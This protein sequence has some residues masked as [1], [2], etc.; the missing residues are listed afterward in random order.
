MKITGK[1]W[2]LYYNDKSAWPENAWH[3]DEF[4]TVNGKEA[5]DDTRLDRVK[6][7]DEIILVGGV[8]F[9]NS[10]DTEGHSFESHFKKWRKTQS[11]SFVT[12]FIPFEKKMDVS[13]ALKSLGIKI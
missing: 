5:D 2:K 12:I 1:E 11:G 7:E 6:D 3:E 13:A 8:R 9:E 4:I 10:N